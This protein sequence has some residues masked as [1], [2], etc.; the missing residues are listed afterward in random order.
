M[1]AI[2]GHQTQISSTT[3]TWCWWSWRQWGLWLL[4]GSMIR[5][6]VSSVHGTFLI[7]SFGDC[8][9]LY[10]LLWSLLGGSCWIICI[11]YSL[12]SFVAFW[13]QFW[14]L[15]AGRWWSKKFL[16]FAKVQCCWSGYFV[17][18]FWWWDSPNL[19]ATCPGSSYLVVHSAVTLPQISNHRL[20]GADKQENPVCL[21]QK[22]WRVLWAVPALDMGT[23]SPFEFRCNLCSS[24]SMVASHSL[25]DIFCDLSYIVCDAELCWSVWHGW[26]FLQAR[27]S[28][29]TDSAWKEQEAAVLALGAVA[30]GCISGLL[31]HLSQ[32][33]FSWTHSYFGTCLCSFS[34][35]QSCIWIFPA[36]A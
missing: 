30:E 22:C 2:A 17:N 31:P 4:F 35:Q 7:L 36:C 20:Q 29:T 21:I 26:W 34:L 5:F 10:M 18:C 1:E 9:A 24:M 33:P 28:A 16:E 23:H 13:S 27:L 8:W 3:C 15:N 12:S 19:D 14:M 32:V 11:I 6:Y 25:P